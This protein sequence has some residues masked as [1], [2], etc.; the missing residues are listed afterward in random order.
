MA[1]PA[2]DKRTLIRRVYFDLIGLPPD[3]KSLRLRSKISV[4]IGCRTWCP[5]L[6][7]SRH[8]GEKW[9]RHWLDVA[10]YGEDD[11]SGNTSGVLRERL[12]LSRLGCE[13]GE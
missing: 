1:N 13:R 9:G 2:A 8:F 3:E 12:A 6:L 4:P 10:R 7:S 11:F 5:S